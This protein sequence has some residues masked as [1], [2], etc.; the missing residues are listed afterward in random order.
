MS[1][2]DHSV[3]GV[4]PAVYVFVCLIVCDL[5][6]ST[7]RGLDRVWGVAPQKINSFLLDFIAP[8][9]EMAVRDQ[10]KGSRRNRY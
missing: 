3:V 9:S 2:A 8:D 7:A 6:S 5:K 10:L 1:Q 4:L